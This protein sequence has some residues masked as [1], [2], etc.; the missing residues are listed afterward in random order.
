MWSIL[1][2]KRP[3]IESDRQIDYRTSATF[4]RFSL[5]SPRTHWNFIKLGLTVYFRPKKTKTGVSAE[6]YNERITEYNDL[7]KNAK[8]DHVKAFILT[9]LKSN[10]FVKR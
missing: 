10:D 8:P 2:Q 3:T 5:R 7:S 9:A 1:A 4:D 6:P